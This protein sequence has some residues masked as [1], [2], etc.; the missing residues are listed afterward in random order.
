M[1]EIHPTLTKK[2]I[3]KMQSVI[4]AVLLNASKE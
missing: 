3:L 1:F 2:E 4:K